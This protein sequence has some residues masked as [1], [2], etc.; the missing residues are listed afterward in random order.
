[1]SASLLSSTPEPH[2]PSYL[3]LACTVNGYSTITNYD[4]VRLAKSRDASPQRP[5]TRYLTQPYSVLNNLLSPP[6]LVPLPNRLKVPGSKMTDQEYFTTSNTIESYCG[7]ET[8]FSSKFI[9][10]DSVDACYETTR[11]SINEKFIN[12]FGSKV[13]K[14]VMRTQT[15][16][17]NINTEITKIQTQETK[18][19]IQQRVE[20]LY[21]PGAL[22]QG[23]FVKK[24]QKSRLSESDAEHKIE[25]S[26]NQHS[27]SMSD[28]FLS[29]TTDEAA[30]MK[31]ST[32]SPVLPVLRHLRPEFRA[33]LPIINTR[34]NSDHGMQ[35]SN[36]VPVLKVETN[37]HS[38][39]NGKTTDIDVIEILDDSVAERSGEHRVF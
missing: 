9:S 27:V 6:N 12:S 11:N 32:S 35:K 30:C 18:S 33:Q 28:K 19:V 22:A 23:F 10:K 14:D 2:L 26:K 17:S 34:K 1:M 39:E 15:Y 16:E 3:S 38:T 37:G 36:T 31:Q 20:R 25:T 21:G 29:N 7:K 5:N 4:S 24:R 8:R 13:I